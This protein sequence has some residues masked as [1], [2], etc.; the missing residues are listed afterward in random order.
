MR[1][2]LLPE[3]SVLI[4]TYN[5]ARTLPQALESALGQE[6]D[7]SLFEVIV[8]DDGST[9]STREVLRPYYKGQ[10][11]FFSQHH[12]GL[13]AACNLGL[14][15]ARGEYLARLDSDD[16]VDR[17]WL[18]C[19]KDLLDHHPEAT[20]VYPDYVE[21]LEDGTRNL[22]LVCEG[23]L[24]DLM[25]CGTLSR[26]NSVRAVGGFRPFYWEEYDLYL[27]LR[28]QGPFLHCARPLYSFRRHPASMTANV[29]D[30][31]TGWRELIHAWG[32]D[33]LTAAGSCSELKEAI[34]HGIR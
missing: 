12:Q 16:F 29:K 9:D 17:A 22:R 3:I 31:M 21:V 8:V 13:V 32:E 11:R 30:R 18:R 6:L 27:R 24:Y 7:R 26:T 10:V 4:A 14:S 25:A 1:P 28:E 20:C 19:E 2:S 15:Q 23:N 34:A 33:L 5:Q